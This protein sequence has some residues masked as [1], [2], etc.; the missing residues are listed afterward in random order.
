M[1]DDFEVFPVHEFPL[2]MKLYG[3]DK[4]KTPRTA[5]DK[6]PIIVLPDSVSRGMTAFGDKQYLTLAFEDAEPFRNMLVW[7][8]SIIETTKPMFELLRIS[9]DGVSYEMRVRIPN[10]YGVIDMDGKPAHRLHSFTEGSVLRC[11]IDIPCLWESATEYGLS[12]QLVQAKI[13]KSN[14]MCRILPMDDDDVSEQLTPVAVSTY[15]PFADA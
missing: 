8:S 12:A 7:M 11:A 9:S 5:N 14:S 10:E 1:E 2:D 3:S 6:V 15:R 13:I 4:F